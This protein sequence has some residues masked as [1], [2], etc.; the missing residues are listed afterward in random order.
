MGCKESKVDIIE[1]NNTNENNA[2]LPQNST[3]LPNNENINNI[4]NNN[5][6]RRRNVMNLAKAIKDGLINEVKVLL[7]LKNRNLLKM[8]KM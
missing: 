7:S 4:P 5:R 6:M 3:N 8:V 1:V 2:N